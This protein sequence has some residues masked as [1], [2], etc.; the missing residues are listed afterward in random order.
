MPFTFSHAALAAP[1]RKLAPGLNVTGLILGSMAPD[2]EYF[3]ALQAV[4]TIGH[5][6]AGFALIGVPLS[7]AFALAFH[8][9]IKPALPSLLPAIGGIDRFAAAEA[10]RYPRRR[11]S[12][13]RQIVGF[14]VSLYVG[15]LT[16]LFFDGWTHRTGW[17]V[18]RI[19]YLS[20][21]AAGGEPVYHLLQYG[22]SLLGAAIAFFYFTYRW[23]E[24]RRRSVRRTDA[25]AAAPAAPAVFPLVGAASAALL[26]WRKLETS[27]DPL[28]V[29][30]WFVTP[31]SATLFGLFV[32]AALLT[33]RRRGKL[34][35]TAAGLVM[36]LFVMAGYQLAQEAAADRLLLHPRLDLALWI[37]YLWGFSGAI[38]AVS[39]LA[40][41]TAARR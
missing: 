16:H 28:A 34:A 18:S 21:K 25:A 33:G 22:L 32:A 31:F 35:Q 38:A 41:G 26:L 10:A 9:V 17:F 6:T 37:A 27:I 11:R 13:P 29:N 3:V 4:G 15:F 14:L 8:L 19:P 20:F 40:S 30:I 12:F 24:W 1:L 23:S 2:M 39:L 36:L 7:A 5:S